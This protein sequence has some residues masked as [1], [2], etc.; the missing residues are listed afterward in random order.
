MD[1]N[2]VCRVFTCWQDIPTLMWE[3]GNQVSKDKEAIWILI[4]R[5]K[6]KV[7]RGKGGR[8]FQVALSTTVL[9]DSAR[10]IYN[11]RVQNEKRQWT[12][13]SPTAHKFK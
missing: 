8:I 5:S 3:E 9:K 7:C 10:V 12:Q 1:S 11:L 4:L 6:T 2:K 13:N